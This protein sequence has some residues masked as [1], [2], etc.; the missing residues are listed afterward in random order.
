M[1]DHR[2]QERRPAERRLGQRWQDPFRKIERPQE[3]KQREERDLTPAGE[4]T[5]EVILA[6][7]GGNGAALSARL[8]QLE[9]ANVPPLA[10]ERDATG[11]EAPGQMEDEWLTLGE[12]AQRLGISDQQAVSYAA[13]LTDDDWQESD[14]MPGGATLPQPRVRLAA[15]QSLH[16]ARQAPSVND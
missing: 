2:H 5:S 10:A 15:L 16:A 13:H 12:A 14:P 9:L 8:Q 4:I 3:G 11:Q 7:T 6:L 1:H